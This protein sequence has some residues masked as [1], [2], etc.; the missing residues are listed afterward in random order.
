M[1]VYD[2]TSRLTFQSVEHWLR[3]LKDSVGNDIRIMLIGNKCDLSH[4]SRAVSI[5]EGKQFAGITKAIYSH[6]GLHGGSFKSVCLSV[7]Y[8]LFLLI[9]DKH[10]LKFFET[11]C[12]ESINVEFAFLS[13]LAGE[14]CSYSNSHR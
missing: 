8:F 4:L 1:I 12:F 11:S 6:A 10:S 2:I 3:Q 14:C 5:D 7:T 9:L 13:L